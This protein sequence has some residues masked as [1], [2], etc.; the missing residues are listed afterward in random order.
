M[1]FGPTHTTSDGIVHIRR[2]NE[3][4]TVCGVPIAE[5]SCRHRRSGCDKCVRLDASASVSSR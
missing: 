4:Q 3:D 2:E 1:I 5:P